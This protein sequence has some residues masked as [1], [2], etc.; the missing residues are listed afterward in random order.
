MA[1]QTINYHPI[2]FEP[3]C[4]ICTSKFRNLVD[5]LA[6][7]AY[8]PTAIARMLKEM[9][10]EAAK[11][12]DEALRKAVHRHIKD[13]LNIEQ[14]ALRKLVEEKAR[15]A[16]IF[17]DEAKASLITKAAVLQQVIEKGWKQLS[18]PNS[19][20]PY[21]FVLKAVEMQEQ[22]DK[23]QATLMVDQLT[24]QLQAI[25]QAIK[26][27]VP[28]HLWM[29]TIE[30]AREIHDHPLIELEAAKPDEDDFL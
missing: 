30:R 13:H 4:S 28:E 20:V 19:R 6:A 12:S 2:H 14:D 9:D 22:A 1:D 23:Q 29:A 27:T 3:R 16:G 26:E 18:D 15:E 8:R 7:Q 10:E 25:I 11:R 5:T 17:S 24:R 21:E